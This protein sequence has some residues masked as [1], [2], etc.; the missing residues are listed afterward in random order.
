[1][2]TAFGPWGYTEWG[3]GYPY[4][5]GFVGVR[6][7]DFITPTYLRL[8]LSTYVIVNDT[9]LNVTNYNI[10]LRPDSPMSGDAVQVTRV[11]RPARDA[12]VVNS[13]FLETSRHTVGATY[14]ASFY[15]LDTPDGVEAFNNTQGS[16]TARPTKTM[17]SLRAL[18]SHLLKREDSLIHAIV[19]AISLQDDLLGGSR[20]DGF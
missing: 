15:S 9:Y 16:Y 7:V 20:N 11:I 17:S 1:M 13:V 10:A 2:P 8:N 18:P 19:G 3:G 4:S 6:S 14:T 12:L 5:S